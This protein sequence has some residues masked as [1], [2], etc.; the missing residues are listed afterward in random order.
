MNKQLKFLNLKKTSE[1]LPEAASLPTLVSESVLNALKG[2]E[3]DPYMITEAIDFPC[4]GDGG[5]YIRSFFESFLENMKLRPFGG[6]KNGHYNERNDFYTIGGKIELKSEKEGTAY[7]K[8]MVPK[9][10]NEGRENG[11]AGFIR[12]CK[13]KYVNFSLVTY[14]EYEEIKNLEGITVRYMTKSLRGERN[15]SV[16]ADNGY[17]PQRINTKNEQAQVLELIKEGNY[18]I[19]RTENSEIIQNEKVS[20]FSLIRKISG[21]ECAE[22]SFYKNAV[23][24]IDKK[25]NQKRRNKGMNKEEL[26]KAL[27]AAIANN[28]ITL[29]EL[30]QEFDADAAALT[31]PFA[32]SY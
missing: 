3:T 19:E 13:A 8:I 5:I 18:F 10:D 22:L 1:V 24:E 11:N 9:M 29:E 14:P 23:S 6:S 32:G 27:K 30:A 15:D 25:E 4:E 28:Q 26:I 2:N 21:G 17:M 16:G 7:F 12:D 20:R 31:F